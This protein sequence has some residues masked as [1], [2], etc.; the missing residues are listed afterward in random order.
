VTALLVV[1][2]VVHVIA[3]TMAVGTNATAVFWLRAGGKDPNRLAF[4]IN[5]IRRL[6]RKLAIPAFGVLFLTGIAMVILGVYDF[7]RGWILLAIVL[8][9]GLAVAG[10]TVM[11]PALKRVI[12]EAERD[13]HSESFAR[14]ERTSMRYTVGSLTVLLVI[15]VLMI[16]KPF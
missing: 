8:Y 1:L 6:D 9:L 15:L 7:T 2:K 16:T 4:T 3:A 11:G 14:A 13:P 5:G 10:M 12:A